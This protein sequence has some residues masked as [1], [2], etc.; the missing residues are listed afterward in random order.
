[1]ILLKK[2][3]SLL[4]FG[5]FILT[6]PAYKATK[7]VFVKC[8]FGAA[9]SNADNLLDAAGISKKGKIIVVICPASRV[10]KA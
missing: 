5:A 6:N 2:F 4:M 10:E 9:A 3:F 1:M 7:E 8:A